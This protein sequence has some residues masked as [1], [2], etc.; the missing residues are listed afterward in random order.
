MQTRVAS[1]P[2]NSTSSVDTLV[3]AQAAVTAS[4]EDPASASTTE[5]DDN[6]SVVSEVLYTV[7]FL[8]LSCSCSRRSWILRLKD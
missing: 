5:G 7:R 6:E 1:P 4:S 3:E 2:S 8:S